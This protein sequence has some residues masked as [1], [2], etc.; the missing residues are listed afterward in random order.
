[1]KPDLLTTISS[2]I[3][4]FSC[5]SASGNRLA[6]Y[7]QNCRY[8]SPNCH[9]H[10][11]SLPSTDAVS[12]RV[13]SCLC[14]PAADTFALSVEEALTHIHRELPFISGIT[15]SCN[16]ATLQ[17]D[18]ALELTVALF[19][20]IKNSPV[21]CHLTCL[22]DSNGC[23]SEEGWLRLMPFMDGAMIDLQTWQADT[24]Q[25]VTARDQHR[26][27]RSIALLSHH[28]K[29]EALKLFYIPG[30]TD[31]EEELIELARCL[32]QLPDRAQIQI[33]RFQHHGMDSEVVNWDI[34][35]HY[36]AVEFT[37]QLRLLGV[38]SVCQSGLEKRKS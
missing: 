4:H 15:I 2:D 8:L 19:S 10:S 33:N 35:T 26:V 18:L 9:T 6:L 3:L 22:I 25:W 30:I 1:M 16:E 5:H 37:E 31:F 12:H 24:H 20:A 7:L 13:P 34:C 36:Q 28:D 11:S 27:I 38:T 23:F 14:D 21:L 17:A 32:G 29:V